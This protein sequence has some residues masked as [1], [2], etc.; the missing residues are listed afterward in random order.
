[1]RLTFLNAARQCVVPDDIENVAPGRYSG[2]GDGV[3][4]TAFR[5]RQAQQLAWVRQRSAWIRTAG[6][7]LP[8][9]ERPVEAQN[10][11]AAHTWNRLIQRVSG[12]LVPGQ[13]AHFPNDRITQCNQERFSCPSALDG[14]P[15]KLQITGSA[16]Q[17]S[18]AIPQKPAA[19][20]WAKSQPATMVNSAVA[21]PIPIVP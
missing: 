15:C 21:P 13:T 19:P 8:K 10:R 12:L 5:C 6:Q 14:A 3:A 9:R 17:D 16:A 11:A 1:M 20:K 18:K 7:E 4:F 2:R